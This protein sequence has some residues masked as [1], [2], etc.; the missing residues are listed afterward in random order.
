MTD[1][2][3]VPPLCPGDRLTRHEFHRRY[4]AM[5]ELKKAEL[6]DGIV[7]MMPRIPFWHGQAVGRLS[8]WL[9]CYEDHTPAAQGANNSTVRFDE[10]NEAQPDILLRLPAALGGSARVSDDDFLEGPPELI[11]EVTTSSVSYD[12]HQKLHV[13]RRSG[14]QEYVVHRVQDGQVDWFRLERGAYANGIPDADGLL[15]SGVFPGLWLDV[16]AQLRDDL[17]GLRA[18]VE[19]GCAT[20]EHA[21]FVARLA[22]LAGS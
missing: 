4:S 17:P 16:P 14:V 7:Y 13:Y 19:R 9:G 8:Y 2:V 22:G 6:I 18:A 1:A 10:D 11:V 12:L 20:A 15:R 5:P 21:A 3:R